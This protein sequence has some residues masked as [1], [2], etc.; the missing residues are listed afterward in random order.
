[1][2]CIG[3]VRVMRVILRVQGGSRGVWHGVRG[4]A[5]LAE[6]V[7]RVDRLDGRKERCNEGRIDTVSH[8]DWADGAAGE[9]REE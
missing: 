2:Q 5:S 7:P 1:M 3:V 6:G 9:G 8:G 4:A